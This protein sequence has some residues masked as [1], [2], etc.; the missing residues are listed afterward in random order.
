[1]HPYSIGTTLKL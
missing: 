1:M